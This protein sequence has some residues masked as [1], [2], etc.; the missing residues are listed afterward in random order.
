MNGPS[1]EACPSAAVR[2]LVLLSALVVLA[3]FHVSR[4]YFPCAAQEC[5]VS[6]AAPGTAVTLEGDGVRAGVYFFD[7]TP[8]MAEALARAGSP[9]GARI[10]QADERLA[11]GT[12]LTVCEGSTDLRVKVGEMDG[13]RRLLLGIPLDLNHASADDLAK[14]PGVG[15]RLAEAIVRYRNTEGPFSAVDEL[16]K[17]RGIGKKKLAL[18]RKDV[19]VGAQT[20][21]AGIKESGTRN[22]ARGTRIRD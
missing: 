18:L 7:H 1:A 15:P 2:A 4:R 13:A 14:V 3:G 8:T 17:V 10:P 12:V 11:S 5:T 16:E 19:R 9:R 6:E 20:E 21:G 22:E